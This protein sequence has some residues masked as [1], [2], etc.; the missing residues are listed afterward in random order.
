ML[1]CALLSQGVFLIVMFCRLPLNFQGKG[2][3]NSSQR[4]ILNNDSRINGDMDKRGAYFFVM[5]AII[6]TAV[7]VAIIM[8]IFSTY[9]I[10]PLQEPTLSSANDF[11]KYL[12]TTKI[13]ESD[14]IIIRN[15]ILDGNIT[16][17][18][19]TLMGQ[20]IYFY[21]TGKAVA[22]ENFTKAVAT[23]VV[24]ADR[25]LFIFINK[26]MVYNSSLH[27]DAATLNAS[28]LSMSV[29]MMSFVMINETLIYGPVWAEVKV[30]T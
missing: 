14:N 18:D 15:M 12:S 28:T 30:W 29:N 25:G 2:K 27:K 3:I 16:N 10:S 24:P 8:F 17:L 19:N 22:L 9:T 6:A 23:T 13:R 20:M 1:A 21:F 11:M 7:I 26:S 5:D 4:Q